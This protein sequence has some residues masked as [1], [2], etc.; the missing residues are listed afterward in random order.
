AVNKS[1]PPRSATI[2]PTSRRAS[3]YAPVRRSRSANDAKRSVLRRRFE[4]GSPGS[5]MGDPATL[6]GTPRAN[7]PE[8]PARSSGGVWGPHTRQ[9]GRK[10]PSGGGQR[11]L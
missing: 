4:G 3:R 9:R 8:T 5:S 10:R 11:N 1:S 6:S 2:A 7:T